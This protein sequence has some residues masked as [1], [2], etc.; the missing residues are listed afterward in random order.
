MDLQHNGL[1]QVDWHLSTPTVVWWLDRRP[2]SASWLDSR[3]ASFCC[4]FGCSFRC[5]VANRKNLFTSH[6][7]A[8]FG[9]PST[10]KP[11][12]SREQMFTRGNFKARHP[13]TS[14]IDSDILRS[15]EL[16][17][18]LTTFTSKHTELVTLGT[19]PSEAGFPRRGRDLAG[20]FPR[21]LYPGFTRN[22][23]AGAAGGVRP[24]PASSSGV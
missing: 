23:L 22:S 9:V 12:C 18:R 17:W 8:S 5:M 20:W 19:G 4:S 1:L 15:G 16:A 24:S 11:T 6:L 21:A 3:D 13:D 7:C 2:L 14:F 10:T